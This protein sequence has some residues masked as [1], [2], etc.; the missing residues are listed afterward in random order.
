M[1]FNLTFQCRKYYLLLLY[2]RR[3]SDMVGKKQGCQYNF[4]ALGF[5]KKLI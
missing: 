4:K 2:I 5:K 3:V 1:D